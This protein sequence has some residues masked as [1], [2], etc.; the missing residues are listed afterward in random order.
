[1]PLLGWDGGSAGN[2]DSVGLP[3]PGSLR[4]LLESVPEG[5]AEG[6]T[7]D[8]PILPHSSSLGDEQCW[9]W[10]CPLQPDPAG[11]PHRGCQDEFSREQCDPEGMDPREGSSP[12]GS[13]VEGSASAA[14][15]IPGQD[16]PEMEGTGWESR[17]RRAGRRSRACCPSLTS[18]THGDRAEPGMAGWHGGDGGWGRAQQLC[19]LATAWG[20]QVAP[21][22]GRRHV[23]LRSAPAARAR[24]SH[25]CLSLS[26]LQ[27]WA[28]PAPA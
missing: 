16:V 25:P 9:S 24:P 6:R 7:R 5:W 1:M 12:R 10:V 8:V 18:A 14:A 3:I 26:P 21:R 13:F 17:S 4:A 11:E 23:L 20:R 27:T 22:W 28:R 15:A 19:A 2:A